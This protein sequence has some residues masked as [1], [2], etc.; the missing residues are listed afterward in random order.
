MRLTPS[1]SPATE[2]YDIGTLLAWSVVLFSTLPINQLSTVMQ[3]FCIITW[4][5]Q[6]REL[7]YP[8]PG[9]ALSNCGFDLKTPSPVPNEVLILSFAQVYLYDIEI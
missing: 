5:P 4:H 1:A 9:D 3:A 2:I 7:P 8:Q 6:S